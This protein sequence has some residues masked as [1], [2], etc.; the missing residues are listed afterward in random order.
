MSTTLTTIREGIV[1]ALSANTTGGGYHYDLTASGQV[2]TGWYDAPPI[3]GKAC[4]MLAKWSLG[5]EHGPPLTREQNTVDWL[6]VGFAPI[7]SDAMTDRATASEQ[8]A[9]DIMRS[10]RKAVRNSAG[11][12]YA[13]TPPVLDV[14]FDAEPDVLEGNRGEWATVAVVAKFYYRV[15]LEDGA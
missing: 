3:T 4:V 8:L 5:I 10:L 13:T 12:L 7:A 1:T 14:D 2:V 15:G 6:L 11:A 9:G